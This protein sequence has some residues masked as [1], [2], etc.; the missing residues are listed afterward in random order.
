MRQSTR[1]VAGERSLRLP[2]PS[3]MPLLAA[4]ILLSAFLLFVVQPV[5]AKQI[6][7]WFGG[8]SAVWAVCLA[9][10]QVG[11][12]AGYAYAHL[13]TRH[14]TPRRQRLVHLVLLAACFAWLP[15]I[16]S[17]R[18]APAGATDA[19]V[20]ILW[21]LV[22][23]IGLPYVVLSSTGPLLQNWVAARFPQRTVYRLFALSN[24]GSL[25]GLLAYPFLIEPRTG[26][27]LQSQAWSLGFAVFAVL[28]ATE[29]W[30]RRAAGAAAIEVPPATAQNAPSRRPSAL[31][32]ALWIVL[33]ALGSTVLLAGTAHITQNVAAVPFFWVVP[34]AL[35][36]LSFIVAFEGG[37]GRDSLYPRRATT[38]AAVVLAVLMAASLSAEGGVLDVGLTV[39]LY[40]AG[41]LACCLFCHGELALRRPEPAH[42]TLF[43]LMVAL[44]GA[45]GGIG[46]ALLAPRLLTFDA[47]LPAALFAVCALAILTSAGGPAMGR[48]SRGV[49]VPAA[50]AATAAASYYGLAYRRFIRHDV[51]LA[52]RNFYGTLRVREQGPESDRVR[53]L[54]HG[55]ILHGE[56]PLAGADRYAPGTY[57]G[58]SSGVGLA[59][60]AADVRSSAA[61]IG[62]VGLGVGTLTAYARPADRV[63]IYEIDPDVVDIARRYFD[64]LGHARA[65]VEIVLGDARLS[66]AREVAAAPPRFDVLAIDAFAGDSI[67][68]HLVTRE[69]VA[70]YARAIADDGIIAI[71]ISN[72]FL[73][74]QPVLANVAADLGLT[75]R[76]VRDRPGDDSPLAITDWVLL[77]KRAAAFDA[78]PFGDHALAL[79]ADPSHRLWTDQANDLLT[80]LRLHPG[81]ELEA[82]YDAVVARFKRP[83]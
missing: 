25:A 9:F 19:T 52:R 62:L 67:P 79:P 32:A 55:V 43:Y 22:T 12:L 46:V 65:P 59:I 71:H 30:Q 10:F 76:L 77:A 21:L 2:N 81:L 24:L 39:P 61:R 17:P 83:G 31:D 37:F 69:A 68:V 51:I 74:L 70:L 26:A 6:L 54:L 1:A 60:A 27:R 64:F 72:R 50:I 56:Q 36:L 48:A 73:D 23:T 29:A 16:P 20:R 75:G 63:R 38:L 33:A 47:E 4:T 34:L 57:Y 13:S 41:I 3:L 14:L 18:L 40:C 53:R 35:Y 49:L 45:L 42:L 8:G 66:L 11:L 82:I 78:P 7:P 44:G 15:A 80:I 28:C 58:P 5:L